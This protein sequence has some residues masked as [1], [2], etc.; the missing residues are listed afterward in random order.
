ML[1][2]CD[3]M[4]L[5]STPLHGPVLRDERCGVDLAHRSLVSMSDRT[6]QPHSRTRPFAIHTMPLTSFFSR[7]RPSRLNPPPP[8]P[9]LT[10]SKF[11][12][13]NKSKPGVVSLP[14]G[15]QYKI[16]SSGSGGGHPTAS[17]PCSCHY[18]GRTA[19]NYPDGKVFDSS[20]QRNAPSTFA[21]NQVIKGWTKAMQLM[22]EGDKW[23]LYIPSGVFVS[24]HF[25]H[26]SHP[27]LPPRLPHSLFFLLIPAIY[28]R[29]LFESD[30]AY[31]DSGRPPVIGGGDVL[32]FTLELLKIL[33]QKT[34]SID[35]VGQVALS[36]VALGLVAHHA[37]EHDES[38]VE[39]DGKHHEDKT[40]NGPSND[41]FNVATQHHEDQ[42]PT[43][44]LKDPINVASHHGGHEDQA[45]ANGIKEP[46]NVASMPTEESTPDNFDDPLYNTLASMPSEDATP[47]NFDDPLYSTAS[48]TTSESMASTYGVA[49][50][51]FLGSFSL[52]MGVGFFFIK[53][54]ANNRAQIRSVQSARRTPAAEASISHSMMSI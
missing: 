9:P 16:I 29:S 32:I 45:P 7:E 18:E 49:A 38:Q 5:M 36:P 37:G 30:L 28:H 19:Q 54:S 23:E 14:S 34:A 35:G 2:R 13:E 40:P 6:H 27:I 43:N 11:L 52:V 1:P 24:H 12:E 44:G 20:Y 15:L 8:P 41:P 4:P 51:G 3:A 53:K 25:P 33:G 48:V 31:G 10:S 22:S 39:R 42:T 47:D 50:A 17:S 26:M 21:P 46:I